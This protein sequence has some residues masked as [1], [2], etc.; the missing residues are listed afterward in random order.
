[1]AAELQHIYYSV[2]QTEQANS[3]ISASGEALDAQAA[4]RGLTRRGASAASVLLTIETTAAVSSLTINASPT[5]LQVSTTAGDIFQVTSNVTLVPTYT[6][7]NTLRGVVS[8][9]ALTPGLVGNV[10]PGSLRRVVNPGVVPGYTLVVNNEGPG[11]GGTE[12]ETDAQLRSRIINIVSTLNQGTA[13]FYEAQARS[14]NSNIIRVFLARGPSLNEVLV[15]CLTS[16]GATLSP[17]EKATL[18]TELGLV[19]PV[20][21]QVTVRDMVLEPI[22]VSFST[23]LRPGY[24]LSNVRNEL[25]ESYRQLLNWSIWPFGSTVQ[26]DDLIRVASA[27]P[28]IDRL[29]VSSF[30]PQQDTPM[31]AATLPRV[32][33]ITIQDLS[34]GEALSTTVPATSSQYPRLS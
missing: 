19:S 24:T 27:T 8:A 21:T 9:V 20:Q 15:Y 16:N 31:P 34:S 3:A 29:D 28:G 4:E 5:P 6:G 18:T 12:Q 33:V 10:A 2:F 26:R 1:V 32:G 30:Y 13:A 14:I 22:N 11:Q 17:N 25:I 7:S 23:T